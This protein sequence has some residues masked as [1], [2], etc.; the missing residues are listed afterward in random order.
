MLLIV[1]ALMLSPWV[2]GGSVVALIFASIATNPV[3]GFRLAVTA[4][5][6]T[7]FLI[8]LTEPLWLADL[9]GHFPDGTPAGWSGAQSSGDWEP[10]QLVIEEGVVFVASLGMVLWKRRAVQLARA[11]LQDAA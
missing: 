8:L 9:I 3:H 10:V 7:L 6:A 1:L 4:T 5:L 2:L 11:A